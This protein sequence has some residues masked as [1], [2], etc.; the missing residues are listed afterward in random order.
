LRRKRRNS[1]KLIRETNAINLQERKR[2]TL[3]K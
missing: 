2:E 1:S 3:Q